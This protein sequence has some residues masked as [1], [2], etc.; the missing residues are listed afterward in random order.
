MSSNTQGG[1]LDGL[2]PKPPG[3]KRTGNSGHESE[4]VVVHDRFLECF[5][6]WYFEWVLFVGGGSF[7]SEGGHT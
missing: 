2:F 3:L 1:L 5:N 6:H 4:M 7:F